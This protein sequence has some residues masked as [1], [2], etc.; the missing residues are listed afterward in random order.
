MGKRVKLSQKNDEVAPAKIAM[1]GQKCTRQR[2]TNDQVG[3]GGKS[4]YVVYV[5][6][7]RG[8]DMRPRVYTVVELQALQL[9]VYTGCAT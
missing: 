9:T 1:Q 3:S 8:T 5:R 6:L 2:K 4:P 7:P